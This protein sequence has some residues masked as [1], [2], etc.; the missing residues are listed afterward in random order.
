[1]TFR[2]L[3]KA[4]G[5]LSTV[6]YYVSSDGVYCSWS[7]MEWKGWMVGWFAYGMRMNCVWCRVGNEIRSAFGVGFGIVIGD[8]SGRTGLQYLPQA[9]FGECSRTGMGWGLYQ[10]QCKRA[11][12]AQ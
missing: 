4:L 5:I 11:Y 2:E 10:M 1:M 7:F 6:L 9:K 12:I 3:F 8:L